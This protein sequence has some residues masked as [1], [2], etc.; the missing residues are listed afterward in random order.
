MDQRWLRWV[1]KLLPRL[2]AGNPQ[3]RIWNFDYPAVVNNV[4]GSI[5]L[6]GT[7]R[8]DRTEDSG[9]RSAVSQ[10]TTKVVAWHKRWADK[11]SLDLC[12]GTCDLAN[13]TAHLLVFAWFCARHEVRIQT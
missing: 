2:I 8:H 4:Q 7:Q 12:G 6:F 13:T 10:D 9:E 3:E 5:R 11:Y 1:N